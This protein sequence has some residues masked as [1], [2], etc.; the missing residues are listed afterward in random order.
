M[1]SNQG[2]SLVE[3]MVSITISSML[4]VAIVSSFSTQSALFLSHTK[5]LQATE[6]GR[7]AFEVITRLLQQAHQN[8]ITITE[9][10]SSDIQIDFTLP[11][12]YPIWPNTVSP[13]D[14]NAVRIHW[15]GDASTTTGTAN[16]ITI[17]NASNLTNLGSSTATPLAGSAGHSNTGISQLALA[18]LGGGAYY[19]LDLSS[20]VGINSYAIRNSFTS[21]ILPRN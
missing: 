9:N 11:S 17:A 8:S 2:F 12:G 4:S 6:D 5:R 20:K 3:M 15:N 13:Y 1:N 16:Q 7:E 14:K 10:T 21:L 18:S 19:K